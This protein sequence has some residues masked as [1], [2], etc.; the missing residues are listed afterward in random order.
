MMTFFPSTTQ[1]G[2]EPDVRVRSFQSNPFAT[3]SWYSSRRKAVAFRACF[4]S[5]VPIVSTSG[6]QD[7]LAAVP[8]AHELHGIVDL[9]Q[10]EAVRDHGLQVQVRVPE[11]PLHPVPVLVHPPPV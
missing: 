7:D 11:Q 2:S 6:C 10:G 4:F 1:R 9:L 3:R 8:G 5:I